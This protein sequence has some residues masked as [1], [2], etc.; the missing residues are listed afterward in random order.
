MTT[1]LSTA[2]DTEIV[3]NYTPEGAMLWFG[4]ITVLAILASGLPARKATHISVRQSLAY[5]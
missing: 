1:A 4:I 5:A 2:V 3:Y